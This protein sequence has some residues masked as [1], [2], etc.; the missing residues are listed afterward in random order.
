MPAPGTHPATS[1]TR[2]NPSLPGRLAVQTFMNA[3]PARYQV[4]HSLRTC[5]AR[6]TAGQPQGLEMT[7]SAVPGARTWKVMKVANAKGVW[8]RRRS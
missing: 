4:G 8:A 6:R 1:I 3:A 5:I 2:A 7:G